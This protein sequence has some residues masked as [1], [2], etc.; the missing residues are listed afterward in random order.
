MYVFL[1]VLLLFAT[2]QLT[3]LRFTNLARSDVQ[4]APG[5]LVRHSPLTP[6]LGLQVCVTTPSFVWVLEIWT[7]GIMIVW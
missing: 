7:Q 2:E 4:C 5:S 3:S 6:A 1:C